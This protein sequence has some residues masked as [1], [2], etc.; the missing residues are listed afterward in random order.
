MKLDNWLAQRAQSCPD[1][2]ALICD[3]ESMTYAELE[4]EAVH[5]ARRLAAWGVRRGATVAMNMGPGKNKV[6]LIHALMKTGAVLLPISPKLSQE[7]RAK[8][9]ESCGVSIDLDEPERLTRTEADMPLLGEH[10]M[11]DPHCRIL[12]SGSTGRP[13]AV[14]LSYGNHLFS[15]MGSAFNIG[16]D[17]SDRWLCAL[18]T[19]HISG[20]SIVMR[21]AIYGTAMVLHDKFEPAAVAE[22]IDRDGVNVISMVS[23]MLLRLLDEGVDISAPRAILVGGG[24]VP[25]SALNE[26]LDRGARVIQTYGLTETCSQVTT[27]EVSEARRKVGSV[28]RPLLTSHLRIQGGEVL[29]QGPTVS[30]GALDADGWLHTGDVGRIDEDG[31]LFVQG[32]TDEMIITGG[33]NVMPGEVEDV[34][35]QHPE[36][37]EAA[38]VGRPDP[39]WQQAITAFVVVREG[40]DLDLDQVRDH[41]EGKLAAYKIPKRVEVVE[42]LPKTP[43]GKLHRAALLK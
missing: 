14:S 12:T 42:E 15:A 10:D 4:E 40:S 24:P 27:L 21:S 22:A 23:T 43:S 39:E 38:V 31:F 36:I 28:G 32:R 34:L 7:E 8:A 11:A 19:S 3:G 6:I 1:R 2:I 16:V 37:V 18:P 13:H 17:P 25:P 26:A 30:A 20:L 33:E 9:I 5:A 35:V 41:C 29:V